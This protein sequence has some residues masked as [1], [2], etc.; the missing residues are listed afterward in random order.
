MSYGF[1]ITIEGDY[2]LF[3]RSDCKVERVSY[4]VPPPS[5]IEG[6]LKCIYWKPC[7]RYD[8]K[9]IIVFNEIQ[10]A[11][12]R[13]NEVKNKI[14]LS[15]V[16]SQMKGGTSPVIYTAEERS[17][18]ASM[19]LKNVK[20]GIEFCFSLTGLRAD[21]EDE[22][23]EKHYNII[24]RRL[25]KG[26]CFR[27][28]YFGCREFGVHKIEFVSDF[29]YTE[30]SPTLKGTIDLGYMLYGMQFKDGGKPVN[31]DWDNPKF[32]DEADA[33]FYHPYLVD[34]IIDVQKYKEA[35]KC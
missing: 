27:Q 24:K 17:Q 8:I 3:T 16:K 14:L 30:I 12:I 32:S 5:A 19:L 23:E 4:D 7:I 28:P 26:Q 33:M 22:C 31:N 35:I 15:K 2:A 6:I 25:E 9:R 1:K 29:N 13:R 21:K 18:R 20:Y 34:G 10:Y 11:N